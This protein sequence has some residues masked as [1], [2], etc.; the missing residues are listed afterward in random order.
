MNVYNEVA[1][2]HQDM[3]SNFGGHIHSFQSTKTRTNIQSARIAP[4]TTH[5][6][7]TGDSFFDAKDSEL[8]FAE[9]CA[10][11]KPAKLRIS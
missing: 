6:E 3:T 1:R 2:M 5:C 11:C 10:D 8:V 4:L 7:E 9:M